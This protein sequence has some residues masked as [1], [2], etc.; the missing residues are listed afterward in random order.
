MEDE[1]SIMQKIL[2]AGKPPSEWGAAVRCGIGAGYRRAFVV[3]EASDDGKYVCAALNSMLGRWFVLNAPK[4]ASN[5]PCS[6]TAGAIDPAAMPIPRIADAERDK[7]VS[8]A[9]RIIAAKSAD[10][11]ADTA[12]LEESID[13]LVFDLYDLTDEETAIVADAFWDGDMSE[14]EEDAALVWAIEE[15][16]ARSDERVSIEEIIE[17]LRDPDEIRI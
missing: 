12:E 8:L 16:L 10:P 14:E 5:R 11:D 7:F 13:W 17:I 9:N 15:E 6:G 1:R 2:S 4:F 3:D